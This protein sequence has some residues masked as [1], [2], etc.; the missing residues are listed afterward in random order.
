[1]FRVE[2]TQPGYP[3]VVIMRFSAPD[4]DEAQRIAASVVPAAHH[5]RCRVV[6]VDSNGKGAP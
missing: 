2:I 4:P 6:A 5:G 3:D 1:M